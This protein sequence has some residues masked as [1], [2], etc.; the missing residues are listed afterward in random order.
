MKISLTINYKKHKFDLPVNRTLSELLRSQGFW[1][2]KQGCVAG[3]C[4]NC[5]VILDGRAVNSCIMLAVQADA[6]HV[7]TFEH[8]DMA[9]E[10]APLKEVLMDFGDIDCGY[11]IPGM[12]MAMKALLDNIP[13]PTEEEI[14]DAL[15]GSVCRCTHN[16][17][18][19]AAIS[20]ALRLMRGKW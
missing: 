15:D 14:L 16:V 13:D 10:F 2:V 3:D 20:E 17:K 4:G 6:M 19:V 18:P 11:C 5:T 9:T 12:M 1:S 8:I 7:E